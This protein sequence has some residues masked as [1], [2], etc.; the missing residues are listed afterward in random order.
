M[1]TF[2]TAIKLS[3]ASK[4]TEH[5]IRAVSHVYFLISFSPW[6][7]LRILLRIQQTWL[8][9]LKKMIQGHGAAQ[10]H[11]MTKQFLFAVSYGHWPGIQWK[12]QQGALWQ[13]SSFFNSSLCFCLK[14]L[15]LVKM[16]EEPS[17]VSLNTGTY[18]PS[19]HRTLLSFPR[20][21][22]IDGGLPW[23]PGKSTQL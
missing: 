9:L 23:F 11:F 14:N 22:W 15:F 16:F 21:S 2:D 12:G 7:A 18:P 5:N 4:L 8:N 3:K 19:V 6:L 17:V 13:P 10:Y 1:N 20:H